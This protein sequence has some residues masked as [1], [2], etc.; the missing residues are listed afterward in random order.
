[1]H[2]TSAKQYTWMFRIYSYHDIIKLK[3]FY[4]VEVGPFLATDQ[5]I[6][7]VQIGKSDI[8]IWGGMGR[9]D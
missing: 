6:K 3:D 2:Y 4:F 5:D 1:M 7:L 8:R 9:G